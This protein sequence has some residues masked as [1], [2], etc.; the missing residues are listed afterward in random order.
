M[1]DAGDLR[2][3]I[4]LN[5]KVSPALRR[6]GRRLWWMRYGGVVTTALVVAVIVLAAV[7]AFVL[8]TIY[9]QPVAARQGASITAPDGLHFGDVLSAEQID[10]TPPNQYRGGL[11]GEVTCSQDG[12]VVLIGWLNLD[13]TASQDST[14]LGPSPSWTGGAASCVIELWSFHGIY[15]AHGPYASDAF[16]VAG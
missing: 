11:W 3:T 12:S 5:D 4:R 9:A 10:V 16:G 1:A 6:I 15:G 13:D 14:K 2:V 8:G 7:L